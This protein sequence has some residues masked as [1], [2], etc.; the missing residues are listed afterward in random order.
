ME[1]FSPLLT[2]YNSHSG[3]MKL[4][5]SNEYICTILLSEGMEVFSFTRYSI[6]A[7]V[8]DLL[9]RKPKSPL[10]VKQVQLLCLCWYTVFNMSSMWQ[11]T[12]D[13]YA[14][15]GQHC[16]LTIHFQYRSSHLS[17][18]NQDNPLGQVCNVMILCCE[19]H[20]STLTTVL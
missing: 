15:I 13:K 6:G 20:S 9:P 7:S 10:R 11:K 17:I 18:S 2:W 14:R 4:K 19:K 5:A 16:W 1:V 12:T 8:T 3:T